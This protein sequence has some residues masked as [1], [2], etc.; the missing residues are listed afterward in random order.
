MTA[1]KVTG[2][3]AYGVY[4]AG[5]TKIY[6]GRIEGKTYGVYGYN[7]NKVT[8]GKQEDELNTTNPAIYGATYG[9]G[10][11]N[12]TYSFNFYNGAII[13]NTKETAYNSIVNLREKHMTYT[14]FDNE[15]EKKYCTIL[16]PTVENITMEATP[17]EYTN[18][19]VKV[20]ITYPYVEGITRQYSED[21]EEWKQAEQYIQELI[22]TENKTIYARTLNESG[23][24]TEENQIE[25]NNIDKEKPTVTVV[26]TTTNY[27]VADTNETKDIT[28]TITSND[29]GVS[30][31]D[32][33]QYAWAKEGEE[34]KYID[35]EREI[36]I[37]KTKLPIGQYNLYINITDKAGNKSELT[38][39]RYNVKYQDPVAQIGETKYVTIQEAIEACSKEAGETQTT[40]TIIK[41]TDEEF[42]TY[43]GQNIMLDL[44][45]KTVGSSSQETPICTNN[46]TLQIINGKLESLNGTAIENNGTL[47]IGDKNTEIDNDNPTIYGKKTGIKNTNILNFYDGKIKG[48]S[49]IQGKVTETPEEY[50]PVST[51]YENGITTVQ[52]GI[53]SGYVARIEWVYY[54]TL[55]EAI[56]ATKINTN[57]P[58]TVTIIKDIQLHEILEVNPVQNVILD[59]NGY[60]LTITG[61]DRVIN[62]NGNLEITDSSKEQIGKII[63]TSTNNC[64]GL[65]N[66]SKGNIKVIGGTV[67]SINNNSN[68]V[69]YGIYNASTGSIE[70]M[71]GTVSSSGSSSSSNSYGIYNANIGNIKVVE[72]TVSS[73]GYGIYNKSTGKV[74][75]IG[76]TVSS[77]NNYGIYNAGTGTIEIIGGLVTGGRYGIYNANTANIEVV[78]GTVSSNNYGI[79]NKSTGNVKVTGGVISSSINS[80][81]VDNYGIYNASIGNVVIEG[82]IISISNTSNNSTTSKRTSYGIYNA[83]TGK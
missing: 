55:Q 46:G 33:M 70:I 32:K 26:P 68:Y 24:I 40:I 57:N 12:T 59:L 20:K 66:N 19:N 25:I 2:T 7:D 83:S 64:Y 43:E 61:Q 42:R 39:I 62:N 71:G 36:T 51:G 16:I 49:P 50:G 18:Q 1:G 28:L 22:V 75:V 78:E 11:R 53:V 67:S 34:I 65:Y 45:G 82:G 54:T 27:L 69:S 29:T 48:I 4:A 13:S 41:N 30:G 8:I 52:L 14:Y 73:K 6:G 77:S 35:F 3:G 23:I 47:T 38:Q 80:D 37:N 10:M 63:I 21:G 44:N 17:T 81:Q 5:I 31:L 56:D 72:G 60:T 15:I 74:E 76:G 79:Y 58:D 9:I